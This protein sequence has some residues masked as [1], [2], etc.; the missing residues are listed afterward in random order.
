M[1]RG[2]YIT[3]FSPSDVT[4]FQRIGKW[5]VHV[6]WCFRSYHNMLVWYIIPY[7][8]YIVFA[9]VHA[10]VDE[11]IPPPPPQPRLAIVKNCCFRNKIANGDPANTMHWF[12]AW[13][14]L[15]HRLLRWPNINPALPKPS[16]ICWG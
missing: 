7:Q 10:N 16:S 1:G 8:H 5:L 4:A 11:I 3:L 12:N 14:M 13:L 6:L 9:H 15:A 2:C